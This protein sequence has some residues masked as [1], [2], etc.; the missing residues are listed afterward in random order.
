MIQFMMVYYGLLG[1]TGMYW[2]ILGYGSLV[3]SHDLLQDTNREINNE[4]WPLSMAMPVHWMANGNI[5]IYDI[6]DIYTSVYMMGIYNVN[7]R[8]SLGYYLFLWIIYL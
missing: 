4:T 6:Y 8:L 1:Y 2:D 7:P 5:Y 3:I